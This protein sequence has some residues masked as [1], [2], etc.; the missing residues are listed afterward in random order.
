MGTKVDLVLWLA[1][2][3][4][5]LL[6]FELAFTMPHSKGYYKVVTDLDNWNGI[7]HRRAVRSL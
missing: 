1:T 2:A 4:V 5:F 6:E 7:K 3:M